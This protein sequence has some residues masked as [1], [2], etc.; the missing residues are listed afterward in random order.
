M[1]ITLQPK[2]LKGNITV[3]PSKSLL[4]RALICAYLGK[5]AFDVSGYDLSEDITVTK[6]ALENFRDGA[7]IDCG[8][9]G[10]TLRFLIPIACALGL[11][12]MFTGHGR[13]PERPLTPYFREFA[14]KG[15]TFS[16]DKLPFQISGKLMSG[17]FELE[18]DVSSQF[19]SGLLFALPILDGDSEIILTT[20]H[21]S[22]PYTDMTIKYLEKCGITIEEY[23]NTYK[24]KG[25]Q[26]Y[27]FTHLEIEGDFSQAAFF[28]TANYLG[29]DINIT[30]LPENSIQGDKKILEILDDLRYNDKAAVS[31]EDI[32]D[33]V[34][35]L[36]VAGCFA[37]NG[38]V[39]KNASR[40]RIKESD[41]LTAIANALNAIGGQVTVTADGLIVNQITEFKGGEADACN[42][43]R[44]AM[45][46][47]IAATMST[48]P[49]TIIG[50]ECVKKSYPNFFEHIAQAGSCINNL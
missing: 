50:A 24:I 29:S 5:S 30:N 27:S 4:H 1:N 32:P 46:L 14:K 22:K 49:V 41:R 9:S 11:N 44:I 42:D 48:F 39:I 38:L 8:E 25:N 16:T 6:N 40:L 15:I 2:K 26:K 43:H 18:G 17:T 7:V 37:K 20:K 12:I 33:L 23:D 10:S 3:P 47:A 35:I 19:I 45:S 31:A 36:A 34:P 13:L 21:E 28:L